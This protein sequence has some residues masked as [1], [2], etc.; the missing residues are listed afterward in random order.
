MGILDLIK[1]PNR[2]SEDDVSVLEQLKSEYPYFT[3]IDILLTKAYHQ[4]ESIEYQ[5]QLKNTSISIV[6]REALYNLIYNS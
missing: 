2:I 6:D 3:V 4:K 1:N 5:Q